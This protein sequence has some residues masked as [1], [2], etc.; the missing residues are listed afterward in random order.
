MRYGLP[1]MRHSS[2]ATNVA[3]LRVFI[4]EK[5]E[6]FA[7]MIGCS[8]HT[9]QS[10]ETDRLKLSEDL[11]R[12]ISNA[13]GIGVGWLLENKLSA[14]LISDDFK[15]FTVEDYNQRR[16]ERELGLVHQKRLSARQRGIVGPPIEL[17][18]IAFYAWMRAIFATNDGNIALWQTG[19]FLEKLAGKYGHNRRIISTPK[20]EAAALR[21]FNE[22]RQ[23]ADIGAKFIAE[24]YGQVRESEGRVI[25]QARVRSRSRSRSG[26]KKESRSRYR[27]G[28]QSQRRGRGQR[29]GG[30]RGRGQR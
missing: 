8:V 2:E 23:H 19:K 1:Q 15:P 4:G 3:R 5:Q 10:I 28:V 16:S 20:L 13:T 21:D 12:R 29:D 27:R 25:V 7:E 30:Q 18:T 14:P 24:K 22:L 9:L 6:A 17:L 11:A 26:A